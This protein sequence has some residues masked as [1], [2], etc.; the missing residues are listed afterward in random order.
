MLQNMC[1]AGVMVHGQWPIVYPFPSGSSQD[2]NIVAIDSQQS[3][4]NSVLT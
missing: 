3:M 2:L 1:F 4:T